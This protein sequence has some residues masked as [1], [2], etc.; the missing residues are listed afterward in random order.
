MRGELEGGGD[1]ARGANPTAALEGYALVRVRAQQTLPSPPTVS[2]WRMRPPFPRWS[3]VRSSRRFC[4]SLLRRRSGGFLSRGE[5][6]PNGV[7]A[8]LLHTKN[9]MK[10]KFQ[11]FF[12]LKRWLF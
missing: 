10:F 3:T 8:T 7:K 2:G 1:D 4:R 12:P 5:N 6:D 9:K 11:P